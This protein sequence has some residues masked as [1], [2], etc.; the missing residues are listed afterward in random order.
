MADT[1]VKN[2]MVVVGTKNQVVAEMGANDFGIA[3]DVSFYTA[4]ETD[5]KLSGKQDKGDYATNTALSQ[6]LAQ[7]NTAL[8]QGLA[9]KQDIA[10]AVNYDNITNCIT[11][12]PQ[13]IKLEL[14]DGKI[15]LKAGSKCY[16]ADGTYVITTADSTIT[17]TNADGI[18]YFNGSNGIGWA[19]KSECYVQDTAPTATQYMLWWDTVNNVVKHTNNRGSSWQNVGLPV[20]TFTAGATQ[21]V[22]LDQVFNGFGYMGTAAFTL[23]G[24]KGL[25]PN[26]RNADGTLNNLAFVVLNLI[27]NQSLSNGN[28]VKSQILSLGSNGYPHWYNYIGVYDRPPK[29]VQYAAYYNSTENNF[30]FA[31]SAT[32]WTLTPRCTAGYFS[33]DAGRITL[34]KTYQAFHAVDY[35]EFNE[36]RVVEFREPTV[37]NNYT[38][39]RKY[40]DGW[41]EQGGRYTGTETNARTVSLPVAMA[42]TSYS[43]VG[44]IFGDNNDRFITMS[45]TSTTAI[46]VVVHSANGSAVRG[47]FC[48]QVSGMAA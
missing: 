31:H 33:A 37:A 44:T 13:D 45:I 3:T 46:S 17:G 39:Y 43:V 18:I 27:V 48:W 38:W 23:P 4:E 1:F 35:G 32:E 16:K 19:Q 47:Y 20:G 15:T 41:V 10:T 21:I 25:I 11:E 7:T 24:V 6:G 2:P 8:S 5:A 34:F 36:H 12:I 30:Y 14:S 26:G 29:V 40:S 9:Q 42:N 28:S 22:S